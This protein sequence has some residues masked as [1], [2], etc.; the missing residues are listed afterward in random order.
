[1]AYE[2]YGIPVVNDRP[3]CTGARVTAVHR[4]RFEIVTEY[5]FGFARMKR[6]LQLSADG[7]PTVGDA[8]VVQ[9]NPAG[10]SVA[11]EILPRHTLFARFD[12]WHGTRQLVAAN[13][14]LVCIATS[15]NGDFNLKRLERY[16]ALARESGAEPVFV[17]TK[18]DLADDEA[19]GEAMA[20]VRRLAPD[21]RALTVSVRSGQGM[22]A[23]KELLA[24][25]RTAVLLG[26]SGVGKSSLVNALMEREVMDTGEIREDDDKGRHTTV[27]RQMIELKSG[28]LLIDTPGMRELAMWDNVSGVNDVFEEVARAA[29]GC[30]FRNCTHRHEPGCAVLKG[31]ETGALSPERVRSYLQ[32]HDEADHT[33]LLAR[34][35]EKMKEISK[36]TRRHK[37]RS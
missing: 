37:K 25:G 15:L 31:L 16:L 14:E 4:E 2:N 22:E 1:M 20:Q 33:A 36:A 10:D 5:G 35:R 9:Y 7:M 11:V 13:V 18:S 12:G 29:E 34:K 3:G 19:A 23:L 32:L 30:K 26:S 24:P 28:A 6:G 21:C 17:L 8:I 27:H